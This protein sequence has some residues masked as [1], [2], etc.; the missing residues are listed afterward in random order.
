M[1]ATSASLAIKEGPPKLKKAKE[2]SKS[3]LLLPYCEELSKK[4]VL[5]GPDNGPGFPG[6]EPGSASG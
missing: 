2:S 5:S 6:M 1:K 4:V 3:P